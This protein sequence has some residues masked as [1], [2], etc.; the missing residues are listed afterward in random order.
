MQ[1][2]RVIRNDAGFTYIGVLFAVVLAGVALSL[3]AEV[4][5]TTSQRAK[6]AQLLYVGG[7]YMQ[8]IQRFRQQGAN[9]PNPPYPKT[10]EELLRD[11][12]Y[13]DVRRYLRKVFVDPMTGKADWGIVRAPDGGIMGVYSTSNDKAIRVAPTVNGVALDGE[14][15]SDW[16]FVGDGAVAVA[17]APTA[18]SR[19]AI[20]PSIAAAVA[21][22]NRTSAP[23][24][25]PAPVTAAPSPPVDRGC[26]MVLENGRVFCRSL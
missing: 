20:A 1:G 13:P 22:A 16:R 10:F 6:E 25:A 5:R 8:A 26:V 12:R 21:A 17:A 18:P 4:W 23:A 7:Q 2:A 3:T 14:K 24:P 9:A 11:P 19:S 15:Y